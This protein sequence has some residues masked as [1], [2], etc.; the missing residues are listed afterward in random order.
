MKENRYFRVIRTAKPGTNW[1][2]GVDG[3]FIDIDGDG[4]Y[5]FVPSTIGEWWDQDLSV[6]TAHFYDLKEEEQ[7]TSIIRKLPVVS[8]GLLPQYIRWEVEKNL[9]DIYSEYYGRCFEV[10]K[11]NVRYDI[12]LMRKSANE[13][14]AAFIRVMIEDESYR[15]E[16]SSK[17]LFPYLPEDEQRILK[18]VGDGFIAYLQDRI[19][20]LEPNQNQS[21]SVHQLPD[22]LNTDEARRYFRKAID[23]G[24]MSEEYKWLKG[25]QMLACFARD[26][27]LKLNLNKATNC[28]GTKRI[29]W[30]PFENFFKVEQGKLRLNYNDIQKTGQNPSEI[31]LIDKVF[32]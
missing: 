21:P 18:Q 26:M 25:L 20:E 22:Q 19:K 13:I 16:E 6:I 31:G 10:W 7:Y 15:I 23:L 4:K 14:E 3:R 11:S 27:S 5:R 8:W 28:D 24:L 32:E 2:N 17:R 12:E 29:S 30:K 1:P 9:K